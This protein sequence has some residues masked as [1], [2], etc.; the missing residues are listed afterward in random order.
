MKKRAL[1]VFVITVLSISAVQYVFGFSSGITG[2]S[3]MNGGNSCNNCHHSG[4]TPEVSITGPQLVLPGATQLYSLTISGGQQISGG[5]NVAVSDGA[6]LS[7]SSETQLVNDEITHTDPKSVNQDG[8]VVF[9]YAWTAPVI[10]G[11]VAITMYGAGNSVDGNGS[12]SGDA[13][14]LTTLPIVVM[15]LDEQVYLPMI[16]RD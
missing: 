8:A 6:L 16:R 12:N 3:G 1:I 10:T 2:F 7:L 9:S 4:I 14:G 5:L 15:A 11:T 13:A